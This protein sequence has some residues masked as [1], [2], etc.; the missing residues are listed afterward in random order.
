MLLVAEVENLTVVFS[1]ESETTSCLKVLLSSAKDMSGLPPP[2]LP[3]NIELVLFDMA[4]TTVDD[5]VDGI[6]LVVA[7]FRAAFKVCRD[8]DITFEQA[9]AVRGYEKREAL[10]QLVSA[11]KSVATDAVDDAEVDVLFKQFKVELDKLT[12]SMNTEVT[13]TSATFEELRKRNIKICVGSGF[14]DTTVKAIVDNMGWTVDAYFS[15]EALGAGRPDPIMVTTAMAQFGVSDPRRVVKV[16]DTVVDVEEGRNAGVFTVSVLTGTQSREKL[17]AA[18]PDC[19]LPSVAD[20]P[21]M[22]NCPSPSL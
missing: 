3:D 13:G 20:L 10:R 2:C 16:G 4:G 1:T 12:G 21:K 6:P 19:I 8:V 7:A 9:N 22:F 14:P 5:M 15:S 17:E 11:T 18:G